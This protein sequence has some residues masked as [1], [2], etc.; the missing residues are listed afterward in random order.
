MNARAALTDSFL[1]STR[2]ANAKRAALAGDASNRRYERLQMGDETAVLMDAPTEKGEDVKPFIAIAEFLLAQ[3]LSA[4]QILAKDTEQGFLILEDLGD[5]LYAR[6]VERKPEIEDEIYTAAI[7]ALIA[8]HHAAPPDLPAYDPPL[9]TDLAS[10]AI[11]RYKA[12][13]IG[14][15]MSEEAARFRQIFEPFLAGLTAGKQ[16]LIQRD[17]HA[18]NLLWL[19]GR[20]GIAR[21]G[22]L[23]FQDAMLGHPAYDVLSIL[24]DARRDVPPAL[25]NRM[26]NHYMS[27]TNV[28]GDEFRAAYAALGVQRN[29][30]ILGIFAKLS[31]DMGKRHYIDMIPR[32]WDLLER[33]LD[34]AAL[35]PVASMIRESLPRP[36]PENLKKLKTA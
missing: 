19:P 25:E 15:D 2:W 14:A 16:V 36:T 33:D 4:P 1:N 32:V 5:G 24:Q 22:M 17:Y 10:T 26:I 31:L 30:R 29:M 35:A 34:H 21:V 11:S 28:D 7:D 6:M 18:E 23:D 8:L 9:M 12:G 13:I 3:G 20:T 27:Q